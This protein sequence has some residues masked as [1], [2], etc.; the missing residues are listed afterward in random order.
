MGHLF[1]L[2]RGIFSQPEPCIVGRIVSANPVAAIT[3]VEVN[4]LFAVLRSPY[5]T[6]THTKRLVSPNCAVLLNLCPGSD[7]ARIQMT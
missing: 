3:A 6:P 7:S 4:E 5:T 2:N 1:Y